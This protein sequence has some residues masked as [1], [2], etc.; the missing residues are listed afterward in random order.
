MTITSIGYGDVA[1]TP[2]NAPEQIVGTVLMLLSGILWG[3]VIGTF[4]GAIANLA[5]QTYEF[6]R[7]MDD[8]NSYIAIHRVDRELG[9]RLREYFHQARHLVLATSH[10]RLLGLMSP[11]LQRDTVL[12]VNK[13]WHE[14]VWFLADEAVEREFVVRLTLT[15][16][17]LV[18]APFE[19]CPHGYLYILHR[20]V[21][22]HMGAIVTK[23]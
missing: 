9:Q 15:L 2:Y 8:L 5:P 4:C 20:G 23:G 6:R 14:R 12:A 11:K 18:L 3:Y 17:P 1:A 16:A 7:N 10:Q 22:V 13:D 21:A 19:L